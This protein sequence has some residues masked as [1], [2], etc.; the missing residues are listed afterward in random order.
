MTALEEF[1]E[2][3]LHYSVSQRLFEDR[4]RQLTECDGT[5]SERQALVDE[6]LRLAM[7]VTNNV[8][9][10]EPLL[11][12]AADELRNGG[13][14][15]DI[16]KAL[17]LVS[18]TIREDRDRADSYTLFVTAR[19]SGNTVRRPRKPRV[20]NPFEFVEEEEEVEEEVVAPAPVRAKPRPAPVVIPE[21][22]VEEEES[23]D[24][25]E[26][27]PEDEEEEV[28]AEDVTEDA[29]EVA[30]EEEE[31]AEGGETGEE[32]EEQTEEEDPEDGET[33]EETHVVAPAR[34]KPRPAPV[35]VPEDPAEEETEEAPSHSAALDRP[36][37]KRRAKPRTEDPVEEDFAE[38]EEP[39]A[40]KQGVG[41]WFRG[42]GSS[43]V[44]HIP[45]RK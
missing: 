25:E 38:G 41:S 43:L 4:C 14:D 6:T 16:L 30:E 22:P 44:S 29:E 2:A 27:I 24:E 45:R 26:E 1:Y 28:T 11:G 20:A 39:E 5:V 9:D 35:V 33:G 42:L 18:N 13:G 21:E 36:R 23:E 3:Y 8:I 31:P 17:S 37:P 7:C 40:P 32:S 12:E 10:L 15:R 34:A 19:R